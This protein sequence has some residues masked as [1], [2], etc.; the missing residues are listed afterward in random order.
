MYISQLISSSSRDGMLNSID[1]A[2]EKSNAFE[3]K[4]FLELVFSETFVQIYVQNEGTALASNTH[5]L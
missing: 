1:V 4:L 5:V 2:G 3:A